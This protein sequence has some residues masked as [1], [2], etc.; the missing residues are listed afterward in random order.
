MSKKMIRY[1]WPLKEA[2]ENNIYIYIYI[3]IY[4]SKN[5]NK[6]IKMINNFDSDSHI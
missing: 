1:V 4:I 5:K 2:K 6:Y 3:Y